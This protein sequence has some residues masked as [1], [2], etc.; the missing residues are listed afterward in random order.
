M[1][2]LALS[3]CKSYLFVSSMNALKIIK[4]F[5]KI[6]EIIIWL[7]NMRTKK[8]QQKQHFD[9]FFTTTYWSS[10]N[11]EISRAFIGNKLYRIETLP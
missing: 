7:G 8:I 5:L 4:R 3:L 10:F 11:L 2:S 6:G 1:H 9:F